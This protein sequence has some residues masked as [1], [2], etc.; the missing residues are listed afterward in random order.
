MTIEKFEL[1]NDCD[2]EQ[3]IWDHG[4]FLNNYND[5]NDI[6]DAYK[7]YDFFVSLC[8]ELGKNEK[9][10]ISAK[11]FPYQLPHFFQTLSSTN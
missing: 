1:L 2:K 7:L 11:L 9:A 8:Y 3:V 4:T 5:D 6:C 10:K